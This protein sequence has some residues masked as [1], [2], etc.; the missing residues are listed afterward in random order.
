MLRLWIFFHMSHTIYCF[1]VKLL[2]DVSNR[3]ES[4]LHVAF[5]LHIP[6]H[7][8]RL[9]CRATVLWTRKGRPEP[10]PDVQEWSNRSCRYIDFILVLFT[11]EKNAHFFVTCSWKACSHINMLCL[12]S[13]PKSFLKLIWKPIKLKTIKML[14]DITKSI[15]GI[16][17]SPVTIRLGKDDRLSLEWKIYQLTVKNCKCT[18]KIHQLHL[19][20]IYSEL[21]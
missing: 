18:K 2:S 1:S 17:T 16:Y 5:V 3:Y 6:T 21:N 9:I 7:S 19:K 15:L 12:I 11:K 10:L 13:L 8:T 20:H 4:E 14:T